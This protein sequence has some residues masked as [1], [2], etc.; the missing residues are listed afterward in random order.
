MMDRQCPVKLNG[1]FTPVVGLAQS[2]AF[3]KLSF[4]IYDAVVA[5]LIKD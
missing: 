4:S 3:L 1:L 2:E 5:F